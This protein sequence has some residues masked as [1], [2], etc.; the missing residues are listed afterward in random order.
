MTTGFLPVD[1]KLAKVPGANTEKTIGPFRVWIVPKTG[2]LTSTSIDGDIL[3]DSGDC[4]VEI[5]L[6]DSGSKSEEQP[7][8]IDELGEFELY[9]VES[10]SISR[11]LAS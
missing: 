6:G 7:P 9:P 1:V 3:G 2:F 11:S 10:N 4:S 5:E 8:V